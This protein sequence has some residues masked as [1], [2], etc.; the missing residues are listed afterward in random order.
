LSVMPVWTPECPNFCGIL[1]LRYTRLPIY[2]LY[3]LPC[4]LPYCLTL[5]SSAEGTVG[6]WMTDCTAHCLACQSRM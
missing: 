5:W 6:Q 2:L 4:C 3:M 1:C